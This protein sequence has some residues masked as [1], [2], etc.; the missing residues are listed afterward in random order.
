MFARLSSAARLTLSIDQTE[1]V[2]AKNILAENKIS[3]AMA[4]RS[5]LCYTGAEKSFGI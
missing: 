2:Q 3:H 5:I 1:Y 4:V